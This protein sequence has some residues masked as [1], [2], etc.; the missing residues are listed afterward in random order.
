M[1]D[2]AYLELLTRRLADEGKL[3]EAGWVSLRLM[4]I[5]LDAGATQLEAM[6][7]A[8]MAGAQHLFSSMLTMLDPEE[9]ITEADLKKMDLINKELEVFR[10]E[11]MLKFTKSQGSA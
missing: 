1:A 2:R 6:H 7:M 4:A 9:E 8:F 11:V 10:N 3:I 5:P